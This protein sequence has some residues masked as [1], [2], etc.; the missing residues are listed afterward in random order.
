MK[1]INIL[2]LL[3]VLSQLKNVTLVEESEDDDFAYFVTQR[4]L[5]FHR[6]MLADSTKKTTPSPSKRCGGP[7]SSFVSVVVV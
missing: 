2:L 5:E 7:L 6:K 1:L 3:V 4:M